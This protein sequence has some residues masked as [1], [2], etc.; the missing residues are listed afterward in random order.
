M[1]V[2]S[3]YTCKKIHSFIEC[4]SFC[5]MVSSS[6][7]RNNTSKANAYIY[8][9]SKNDEGGVVGYAWKDGTCDDSLNGYYKSAIIEY[10]Y[11]DFASAV[12]C[13]GFNLFISAQIIIEMKIFFKMNN[14][15][16]DYVDYSP[17]T[18]T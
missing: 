4:I 12:V 8:L 9:C 17:R 6:I 5:R 7:T 16:V 18:W 1:I 11:N 3:N 14:F 10:F 15:F 2:L 13:F